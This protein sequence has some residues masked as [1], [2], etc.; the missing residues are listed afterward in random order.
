MRFRFREKRVEKI[1]SFREIVGSLLQQLNCEDTY[2]V[3]KIKGEW[4]RIAGDIIA[5]HSIPNRIFKGILFISA[6]HSVYAN[7]IIMMKSAL[8]KKFEEFLG[9]EIIKDVKVE[10]KKLA[11]K[12]TGATPDAGRDGR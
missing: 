8:L 3:E 2:I 1:T 12:K 9:I 4:Y 5:T 6:D 11:W 10:I 7:E